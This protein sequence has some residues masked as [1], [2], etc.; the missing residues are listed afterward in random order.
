MRSDPDCR[1]EVGSKCGT[2]LWLYAA[3]SLQITTASHRSSSVMRCL[4]LMLN[5]STVFN[6]FNSSPSQE[7]KSTKNVF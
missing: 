4:V 6:N 1:P 7:H 3:L 5:K 2:S